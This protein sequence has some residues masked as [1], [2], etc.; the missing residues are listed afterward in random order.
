MNQL[1]VSQYR[2]WLIWE[3]D[4][5]PILTI[6]AISKVTALRDLHQSGSDQLSSLLREILYPLS[7]TD[8]EHDMC[9]CL[10]VSM[11]QCVSVYVCVLVCVPVTV[12]ACTLTHRSTCMSVNV[13]VCHSVFM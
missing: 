1:G 13:Y 3:Q 7:I 2:N 12:C 10:C 6:Q 11:P 9:V 8:R 4:S 5:S